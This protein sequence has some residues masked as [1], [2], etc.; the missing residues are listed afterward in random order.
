VSTIP[1]DNTSTHPL[2]QYT[3]HKND[4]RQMTLEIHVLAL[5]I[6]LA[7]ISYI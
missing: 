6:I 1:L 7:S 2:S 4:P 5:D 3:E